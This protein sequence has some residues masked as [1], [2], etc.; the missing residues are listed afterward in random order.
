MKRNI[1]IICATM[2]I[3]PLAIAGG[4]SDD[5]PYRRVI[6]LP[7]IPLSESTC[8]SY[9]IF[10]VR[11]IYNICFCHI[12]LFRARCGEFTIFLKE[13]PCK[14]FILDCLF[15]CNFLVL[16]YLHA[17]FLVHGVAVTCQSRALSSPLEPSLE[18]SPKIVA[19]LQCR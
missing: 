18:N 4:E 7:T 11:F 6:L 15:T 1:L 14:Y 8:A 13:L 3:W 12:M 10:L 17:I 2:F 5:L 19:S 9:V 16:V